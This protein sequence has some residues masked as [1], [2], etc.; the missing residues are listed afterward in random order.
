MLSIILPFHED[1]HNLGALPPQDGPLVSGL[2][3]Q[4]S[5]DFSFYH[6]GNPGRRV[7]LKESPGLKVTQEHPMAEWGS[8]AGP[9]RL[10]L[11]LQPLQHTR[12]CRS[13]SSVKPCSGCQRQALSSW[14]W[15]LPCKTAWSSQ[16]GLCAAGGRQRHS[17]ELCLISSGS[18]G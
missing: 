15:L 17:E 11:T 6:D 4:S 13:K 1:F 10:C 5:P 3:T 9:P 18:G 8:K 7:R 2:R 14:H 12:M 16:E